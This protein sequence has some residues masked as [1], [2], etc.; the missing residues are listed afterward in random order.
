MG[1]NPTI[2]LP[3]S[4]WHVIDAA[5][6]LLPERPYRLWVTTGLELAYLDCTVLSQR[7]PTPP[8]WDE[9]K[10]TRLTPDA[11]HLIFA[12]GLTVEFNQ[13]KFRRAGIKW[14]LLRGHPDA[15]KAFYRPLYDPEIRPLQEAVTHLYGLHAHQIAVL[16][17]S[18]ACLRDDL[19]LRLL[20][21]ASAWWDAR[22]MQH[23]PAYPPPDRFW[24]IALSANF[25]D[26]LSQVP[27]PAPT[28]R[29]FRSNFAVIEAGELPLLEK[30]FLGKHVV[31]AA[32]DD[33]ARWAFRMSAID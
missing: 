32:P 24:S 13:F 15:R 30:E 18:Y 17:Q 22:L 2:P 4:E 25:Q 23:L 27:K 26:Y 10:L 28:T 9:W 16:Q 31:L 29:K 7:F 11:R 20:D 6:R 19:L 21:F 33:K 3:P 1:A 5:P 8:T 14:L 12:G